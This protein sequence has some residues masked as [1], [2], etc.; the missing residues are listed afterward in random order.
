[1]IGD[2]S[3]VANTL[4]M[5]TAAGLNAAI[6]MESEIQERGEVPAAKPG[7]SADVYFSDGGICE[8]CQ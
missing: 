8:S 4:A 6:E 7:I 1:M 2:Q 5:A 3:A